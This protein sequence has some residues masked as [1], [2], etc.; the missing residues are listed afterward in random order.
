MKRIVEESL[1]GRAWV[2]NEGS[3]DKNIIEKILAGRGILDSADVQLFLNP[4]IKNQMPDPFVLKDMQRAVEIAADVITLGQKI[5]V[6]GDYDVDGITSTAIMVKYLT[7][8]GAQVIWHLPA[9]ESE[10]YG[11]NI[12]TIEKFHTDGAKLMISVDCGISGIEEVAR[13]KEL[14]MQV[15]VT[16]HHSPD[17]ELPKAD[18]IV[19]PKRND[20]D[21]GLDYLAGVGVAF[22]FVVALN[23]ELKSRGKAPEDL[24]LLDYL[25]MVALGT[26]CDTMPLTGLNRAFVSTGLK[27]LSRRQNLGLSTLMDVARASFINVYIVGFVLG[28]RLNAAGRLKSA[29]PAL[30][31]LLTDNPGTAR[32]LAEELDT[33]NKERKDIE[34][35]IMLGR[36]V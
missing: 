25:D 13:A 29:A 24:N 3:E 2:V 6:F 1:L 34:S 14:G 30:E 19:N 4:S 17:F 5:A 12:E 26:I 36:C 10:G 9:R 11:L 7:K 35:G 18:A 31:L 28:P 33:Q 21:S 22:M 27:V 16:D 32:F 8:A 23:R 20:D 15:I